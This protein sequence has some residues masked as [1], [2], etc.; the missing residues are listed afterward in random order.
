MEKK[1]QK[2]KRVGRSGGAGRKSMARLQPAPPRF[3][4]IVA[5]HKGCGAEGSDA[6]LSQQEG[7]EEERREKKK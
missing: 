5:A 4:T 6:G 7:A 2:K 3:V 1:R